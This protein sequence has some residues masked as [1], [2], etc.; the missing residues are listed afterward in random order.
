[1]TQA[2]LL[3]QATTRTGGEFDVGVLWRAL[4]QMW[5][6]FLQQIPYIL[7]GILVF[8]A[9]LILG[10][11][12]QKV[13]VTAGQRTRLPLNLAE[14]LGRLSSALLAILGL[15]V[16]AVVVFPAFKPGDLVTGLGITS[17]AIGFAFKDVLQNFF[18]GILLLWRQPFQVGD[19]IRSGIYEGTVEEINTRSTRIKTFDG[20]RAVVPNGDVYTQSILVKTAYQKRRVRVTVGIGYSDSLE[21]ARSVIHDVLAKTEGVFPD[22]GPWVY[23]TEL[24]GSSV[25]FTV[26]FWVSAEQANVLKVTDQVITGIKLALDAAHID[27]PFPHTVVLFHDQTGSEPEDRKNEIPRPSK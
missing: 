3:L 5:V 27:M 14:L 22:P 1:M 6:G 23:V 21:K 18:A 17:V 16:A 9:F 10:R 4:E 7:I 19:Q 24:A 8:A 20:E 13:L 25:N 2:F 15:F 26:F 12:T 11:I